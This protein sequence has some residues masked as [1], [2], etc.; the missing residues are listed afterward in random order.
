MRRPVVAGFATKPLA[1]TKSSD[2]SRMLFMATGQ[3]RLPRSLKPASQVRPAV[4]VATTVYA[5]QTRA[6][7]QKFR[8][9]RDRRAV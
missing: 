5:I 4:S 7:G 8:G 6:E 1:Q 9:A 2:K 3:P